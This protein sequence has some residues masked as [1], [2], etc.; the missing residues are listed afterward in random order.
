MKDLSWKPDRLGSCFCSPACGRGCTIKE[1]ETALK[2]ATR[3]AKS[4]GQGWKPKVFENLGWH[5]FAT[6]P[7][8]DIHVY[9]HSS[10][11]PRLHYYYSAGTTSRGILGDGPTARTAV[12]N[13]VARITKEHDLAQQYLSHIKASLE[14]T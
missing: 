2:E 5:P 12:R 14:K 3:M 7:R 13:M 4:L 10:K 1:Y 9:G 6:L 8:T 11:Y